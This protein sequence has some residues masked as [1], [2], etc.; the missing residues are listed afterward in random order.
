MLSRI[1]IVCSLL[2][3][4]MLFSSC[5]PTSLYNQ[6]RYAANDADQPSPAGHKNFFHNEVPVC[7]MRQLLKHFPAAENITWKRTAETGWVA[8][9]VTG[10]TRSIMNFDA[11]GDWCR[12]YNQYAAAPEEVR[13]ALDNAYTAYS[14]ASVYSVVTVSDETH[15]DFNVVIRNQGHSKVIELCNG[16]LSVLTEIDRIP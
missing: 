6:T 16:S 3:A 2:F 4:G 5:Y 7:A 15:P 8:S 10:T 1:K 14:I 12:I 11:N 9:F 13:K